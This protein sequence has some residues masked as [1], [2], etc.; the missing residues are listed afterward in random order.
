[1]FDSGWF[2]GALCTCQPE[3][4]FGFCKAISNSQQESHALSK[5]RERG[6]AKA[7]APWR[8][9]AWMGSWLR[10]RGAGEGSLHIIVLEKET[11]C[12][13]VLRAAPRMFPHPTRMRACGQRG[14]NVRS[15]VRLGNRK[16]SCVGGRR[17]LQIPAGLSHLGV[18]FPRWPPPSPSLLIPP[19]N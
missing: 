7:V 11:T 15:Q 13:G 14:R 17:G 18:F 16:T 6:S 4:F 10:T 3:S 12:P 19:C 1:M 9:W 5:P 2:S 8:G